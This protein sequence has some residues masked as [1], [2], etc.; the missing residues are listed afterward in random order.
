MPMYYFTVRWNGR[1]FDERGHWF[2]SLKEAESEAREVAEEIHA[3][4][5]IGQVQ[6][7]I[8]D[9]HEHVH[10]EVVFSG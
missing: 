3:R 5:G 6:I 2:S 7:V 10:K 8:R 4:L 1:S 9:E